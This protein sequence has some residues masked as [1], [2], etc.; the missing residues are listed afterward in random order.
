MSNPIA[1]YKYIVTKEGVC[2]GE[3]IIIGTRIKPENIANYG[4]VEEIIEDFD[5]D[6]EKVEEALKFRAQQV[7]EI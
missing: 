4:T 5:L 1:G 6:R 7:N 2:G 3:P